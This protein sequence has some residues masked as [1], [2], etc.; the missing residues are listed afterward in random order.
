MTIVTITEAKNKLSSLLDRVRAGETI[1]IVDRGRP[2]ARLER[3]GLVR[4]GSGATANPLILS[5]PPHVR[6]SVLGA[7]LEEREDA[8]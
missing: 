7:L 1:T 3:A 2:V 5:P 8:R 6:A 4:V